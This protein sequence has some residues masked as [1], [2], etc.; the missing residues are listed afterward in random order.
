[1]I[2]RVLFFVAAVLITVAGCSKE[3]HLEGVPSGE[4]KKTAEY[5]LNIKETSGLAFG[6]EQKTLLTVSDQTGKIYELDLQGNIL[7]K[8]SFEGDDLEGVTFNEENQMIVVVEER[9]REVV[10]I[11]YQSGKEMNRYKI[12]IE[13]NSENKGLEG[14]AWD[15]QNE[16]YFLI[17]E[18]DPSLLL[19]WHPETGIEQTESLLLGNDNSGLF[20]DGENG[21]LWVLS[22]ESKALYQCDPDGNVT[23]QYSLNIHKPEGVAV[24][25]THQ[26]IYIVRDLF[27]KLFVFDLVR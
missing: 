1:M 14:I 10:M 17:N 12:N 4:L 23:K 25:L 9:K 13:E 11:D 20:F 15:S 7:R 18:K 22:D 6:P 16:R 24:D 21:I 5:K 19:K 2:S 26:K 27:S 8:L 3:D